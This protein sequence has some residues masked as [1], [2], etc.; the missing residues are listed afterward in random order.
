MT[1]VINNPGG[2]ESNSFGWI[3]AVVVLLVL[4]YAFFAYGLPALQRSAPADNTGG[5]QI[6]IQV[7]TGENSEQTQ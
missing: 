5:A 6:N 2:S 7:P 4:I 1:T 3:I